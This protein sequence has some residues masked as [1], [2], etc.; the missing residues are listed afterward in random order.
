MFQVLM[1]QFH[2]ASF[3]GGRDLLNHKSYLDHKSILL[4]KHICRMLC[5]KSAG[6]FSIIVGIDESTEV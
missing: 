6:L 2:R 5:C 1:P 3:R 4:K